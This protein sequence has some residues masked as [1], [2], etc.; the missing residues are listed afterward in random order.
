MIHHYAFGKPKETV[1]FQD[2]SRFSVEAFRKL[3][4]LDDGDPDEPEPK[5][6]PKKPPKAPTQMLVVQSAHGDRKKSAGHCGPS[7]VA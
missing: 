3:A 7:H 4:G 1:T 6:K 2:D 5:P